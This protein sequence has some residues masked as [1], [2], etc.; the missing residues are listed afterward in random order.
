MEVKVFGTDAVWLP[1]DLE[2][3][4]LARFTSNS[5]FAFQKK[6]DGVHVLAARNAEKLVILNRRGEPHKTTALNELLSDL[7]VNTMLDG[8]RLHGDGL[9]VFD[10]LHHA[11]E[12]LRDK[13]YVVRFNH[14]VQICSDLRQPLVRPVETALDEME[15]QKLYKRLRSSNAEGI[16]IKDL[17][18]RY[19]PGR[20]GMYRLKFVKSLT[21]MVY[22]RRDTKVSFEMFLLGEGDRYIPIGS[23]NAHKFYDNLKPAESGIAEVRYLYATPEGKLV[24]PSLV[25]FRSDKTVL[26]CLVNQMV[27]GGRFAGR[28][29]VASIK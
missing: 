10:V 4:D 5:L 9:A 19:V 21:C 25:R 15:K 26:D 22:R 2:E 20:A 8:E 24:Q 17:G 14:V 12:D 13:P 29:F 6:E 11:G 3:R 28:P 23:V 7:P 1:T 16:I 18:A 27:V